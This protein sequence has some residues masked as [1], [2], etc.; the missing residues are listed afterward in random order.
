MKRTP[1]LFLEHLLE[2]IALIEKYVPDVT[3]EAFL[4]SDLKL[5][6]NVVE[7]ELPAF[8]KRVLEIL[9]TMTAKAS[10]PNT[11]RFVESFIRRHSAA[12]VGGGLSETRRIIFSVDCSVSG[13]GLAKA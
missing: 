13:L 2:S 5:T 1:K 11:P 10:P 6:W 9:G 3:K 12:P 4:E 7:K 8:K